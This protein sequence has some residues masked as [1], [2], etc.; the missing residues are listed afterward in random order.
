[1]SWRSLGSACWKD[2]V[3]GPSRLAISGP[4]VS[5][6]IATRCSCHSGLYA[7]IRPLSPFCSMEN[8]SPSGVSPVSIGNG[9]PARNTGKRQRTRMVNESSGYL[10]LG[11]CSKI[12]SGLM[13]KYM[14]GP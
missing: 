7:S 2:E 5:T 4:Y 6:D 10:S 12:V 3:F 14:V 1:M 9:S 13:G 8:W 11:F